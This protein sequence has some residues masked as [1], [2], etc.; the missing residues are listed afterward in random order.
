MPYAEKID[1]RGDVASAAALEA[2]LVSVLTPSLNQGRW[3]HD[4]IESV[5]RQTYPNIEHI[6]VDGGSTDGSREIL[7]SQ[8][9]VIWLS[10]PDG[11]QSDALAK[12]FAMSRGDVIGWINADDA[13]FDEDAVRDVVE[14]FDANPDVDV[15]YG[16][17]ALVSPVGRVLYVV[18]TPPFDY[19]VLRVHN[20]I[21]QPAV[22]IRR[23]ALLDGFVDERY[24]YR[25]DRELWLRLARDHVFRRIPRVLAIDRHHLARKSLT[26]PDLGAEDLRRLVRDYAIPSGRISSVKM[27][28]LRVLF[29]LAGIPAALGAAR[30]PIAYSGVVGGRMQLLLRQ[31]AYRRRYMRDT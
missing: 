3:L 15:V 29:R 28:S 8:D 20:F 12:A 11:G 4:A 21:I 6:V 26:R 14:F 19:D 27:K 5:R 25:M 13:Y 10:E 30:A 22:F 31:I 7:E 9:G 17:A 16:H 23:R 1:N 24:G 2:P 18:W